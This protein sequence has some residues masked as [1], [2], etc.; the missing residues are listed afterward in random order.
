MIG[1]QARLDCHALTVHG[2]KTSWQRLVTRLVTHGPVRP[3][4]PTSIHPVVRTDC[5]ISETAAQNI[6]IDYDK[7]Y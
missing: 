1:L 2:T 5:Y 7:G 3:R 4:L 6:E